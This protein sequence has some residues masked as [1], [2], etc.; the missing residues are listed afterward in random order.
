MVVT[1]LCQ[2]KAISEASDSPGHQEEHHTAT[3]RETAC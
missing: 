2:H 3:A 1:H